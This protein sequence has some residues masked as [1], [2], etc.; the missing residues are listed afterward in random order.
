[1]L[2]RVR[3]SYAGALRGVYGEPS[4]YLERERGSWE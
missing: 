2:H 1:V 3:S 4:E